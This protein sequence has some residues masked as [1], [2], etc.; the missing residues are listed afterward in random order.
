MDRKL[1]HRRHEIRRRKIGLTIGNRQPGLPFLFILLATTPAIASAQDAPPD[2]VRPAE[3]EGFGP[4]RWGADSA[5]IGEVEGRPDT[6]RSIRSMNARALIYADR[7]IGRARG[8]LGYLVDRDGGLARILFLA[9]YGSGESC[10]SLYQ[11]LRDRLNEKLSGLSREE[12]LYNNADDLDFCTAFQL[13]QAG[14]RAIWRDSETGARAWVALD[15][16]AG[17]VRASLESPRYDPREPDE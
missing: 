9:P 10:L 16:G 12:R 1:R 11:E 8:S 5:A 4:I 6:V 3:L 15:L 2:S 17:V 7:R 13:G 14:A